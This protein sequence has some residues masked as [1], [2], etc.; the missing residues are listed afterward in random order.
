MHS[1]LISVSLIG[2]VGNAGTTNTTMQQGV[3]TG[4]G[5]KGMEEWYH[6]TSPKE[7]GH[8]G[9]LELERHHLSSYHQPRERS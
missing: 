3:E 9:M 8:K 4:T 5:A 1:L 6:Y 7:G 2:V